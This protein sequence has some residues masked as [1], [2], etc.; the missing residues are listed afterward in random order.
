MNGCPAHVPADRI[1]D[2]DPQTDH[3]A[4]DT[5][6]E[7]YERF[8]GKPLQWSTKHDGFWVATSAD[9]VRKV[10]QNPELFSSWQTSI[11]AS[12][13]WP[14][15][16]IPIE[17]DPPE[18]GTYRHLLA[19]TFSPGMV[20]RLESPVTDICIG[21]IDEIASQGTCDFTLDFARRFPTSVFV[22][23][24]F[25]FPRERT[26][27][28]VTWNYSLLHGATPEIRQAQGAR[29]V[30]FLQEVIEERSTD[31][32]GDDLIRQLLRSTINGRPL[33][34]DEVLDSAFLLFIAGLDTVTT[35]LTF[36]FAFLAQHPAHRRRIVDDPAIVPAAVEELLRFY[37][38]VNP[39]R[40]VAG[41]VEFDGVQLKEG[42]RM[43][44]PGVIASRDP[45]EFDTPNEIDF[46]RPTNRHL[47]FG[48]GP[49]RCLG[50]HLAR[51]ELVIALTEWHKR[52]PDYEIPAGADI[53]FHG[54]TMVGLNSLPLVWTVR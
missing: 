43:H 47:A 15:K 52:I 25:G 34:K 40:T 13:A 45:V 37:A 48:A 5:P 7:A 50:S 11:P 51:R 39:T 24:L 18:H 16:L 42:D 53:T 28:F 9:M 36:S 33:S 12:K 32:V 10:Y 3:F 35:M 22:E 1:T 27:E 49:H 6:F 44:L 29:L 14:R 30:G 23:Y 2:F 4:F 54:G 17:F 46:D 31:L 20:A 41:D 21:L 26:E 19:P 8:R 38:F